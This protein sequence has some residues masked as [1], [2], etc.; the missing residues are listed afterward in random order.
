MDLVTIL[1]LFPKY[2]QYLPLL[3]TL[4]EKDAPLVQQL[5]KDIQ[6]DVAALQKPATPA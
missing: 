2:A 6:A 3:I 4:L 1:G 5:V